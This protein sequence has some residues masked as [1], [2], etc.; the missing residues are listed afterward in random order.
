MT[1]FDWI[2]IAAYMVVVVGLGVMAGS[3]RR[4]GNGGEGSSYFLAG[5][6]LAWPVIGL[7]MFAAN[8]STVHLVSLAEA[9]YKF[10]LVFGNYEWMAGFTL[11]L[12]SLFFAPLYLRSRVATLPD[13][14]ERRF[15]RGCRDV[16]AVASLFSAIVLHM[17][18][19]LYTAA[20]VMRGILGL[21]PGATILGM[22]ALMLIIAGLGL[23]NRHVH[24]GA[25]RVPGHGRGEAGGV[26]HH[27]R[28]SR[29]RLCHGVLGGAPRPP[30]CRL[31]RQ[32]TTRKLVVGRPL[33]VS[34]GI[35]K[36]DRLPAGRSCPH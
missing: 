28:P 20:W 3:R 17:G 10:G 18:V 30:G 8:I 1:P 15:N 23:L 26:A 19:A 6:N 12:L 13:F 5:H 16:L 2:I 33:R 35:R 36:A 9:A 27:A 25:L 7:S 21:P 11:I 32:H 14:L 34:G 22:D 31:L 24:V 29:V 4:T